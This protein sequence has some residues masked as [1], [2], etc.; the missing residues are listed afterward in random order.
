[1]VASQKERHL[2][3]TMKLG[4]S[5]RLRDPDTSHTRRSSDTPALKQDWYSLSLLS[6][7]SHWDFVKQMAIVVRLAPV[8]CQARGRAIAGL[9]AGLEFSWFSSCVC[10]NDCHVFEPA[11]PSGVDNFTNVKCDHF[12][13]RWCEK[14]MMTTRARC[15]T[16]PFIW[17]TPAGALVKAFGAP[18]DCSPVTHGH[19]QEGIHEAD[20]LHNGD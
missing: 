18:V 19:C 9:H 14:R 16:R 20:L 5:A 7:S 3:K 13:H 4:S 11:V 17:A 8:H 6:L 12:I 2:L 15:S 1:M 10:T